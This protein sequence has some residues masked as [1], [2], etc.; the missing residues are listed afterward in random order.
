MQIIRLFCVIKVSV[1][2]AGSIK[3]RISLRLAQLS[4]PLEGTDL[5]DHAKKLL[6]NIRIMV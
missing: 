6:T 3:P 4:K 2:C 5:K 1:T